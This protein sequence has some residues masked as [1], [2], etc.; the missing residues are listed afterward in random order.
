MS[1]SLA[2]R[3]STECSE[4]GGA[5]S[6]AANFC[7]QCGAKIR[8]SST[9]GAE[10]RQVTVVF[11]DLVGSTALSERL[12]P[13]ELRDLICLYQEACGKVVERFGG[14]VAQ[15]LGDGILIY[16][17]YPKA[18]EDDAQRSVHASLGIIEA[19]GPLNRQ[20]KS[21]REISLEVRL[22]IHTG[23]VV[24]GNIGAA[25]HRQEKLALGSTP[26]VA[27]RLQG[28]AEPNAV[29]VSAEIHRLTEDFFVWQ[30]LG[31]RELKGTQPMEVYRA[32]A[33]S[34]LRSRFEV[35]LSRGL[36]PF[37]GRVEQ[38]ETLRECHRLASAGEGRAVLLRG[39]GGIGKSRI[40]HAFIECLEPAC[41]S[42]TGYCSAYAQNTALAP[43]IPCLKRLLGFAEDD[44]DDNR[45][46]KLEQGLE[47]VHEPAPESLIL[48]ASLLEISLDGRFP[49]LQLDPELQRRRTL[50][51]VAAVFVGEAALA[52]LV[53]VIEDLHWIDPSTAVFLDILFARVQHSRLL[54]ILSSRPSFTPHWANPEVVVRLD[55]DRLGTE[56][57]R[58]LVENMGDDRTLPEDMV[59]E[60]V[61][62]ADGIPLFAEELTK[63]LLESVTSQAGEDRGE[64]TCDLSDLSIPD[65]LHGSLM[66]RLDGLKIAK[67]TAQL[68][69][70]VGR[71]FSYELLGQ[72]SELEESVLRS[73]LDELLHTEILVQT[74]T[75]PRL[76]YN[77]RHALLQETAYDSLLKSVRRQYH[78]RIAETVVAGFPV[79]AAREPEYVAL[80]FTAAGEHD[81]AS[82]FWRRAAAQAVER[83]AFK[84][85]T[86]HVSRGLEALAALPDPSH[87]WDW[88]LELQLARG[89]AVTAVQGH[90]L[91]EAEQA[92]SRALELCENSGEN[93]AEIF[94]VLWGLGAI[95][96]VRGEPL[97]ALK[98][99]RRH[100]DLARLSGKPG[101][102]VD[103]C[104]GMGSTR[105]LLGDFSEAG[106]HFAE[107]AKIY[108]SVP[109]PSENPSS[110]SIYNA[111]VMSAMYNFVLSWYVGYPDRAQEEVRS[112]TALAE[113]LPHPSRTANILAWSAWLHQLAGRQREVLESAQAASKLAAEFGFSLQGDLAALWVAWASIS[114]EAPEE[115]LGRFYKVIDDYRASGSR[116]LL[117]YFLYLYAEALLAA[118][119][120]TEA[121]AVVEETLEHVERSNERFSEAD[122]RRLEGEIHWALEP[123]QPERAAK[124]FSHA[125]DIAR[126]QGARSLELRATVSAA[127][128][129]A[130]RG[131]RQR[132]ARTA[133][134]SS[135]GI[136][137]RRFDPGSYS[138]NEPVERARQ[139]LGRG[140]TIHGFQNG[141]KSL[142]VGEDHLT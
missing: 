26:N 139:P 34:G 67:E 94:W 125:L 40:L 110:H 59:R 141:G 107:A 77:F 29:V 5:V 41:R 73:H 131:E 1:D 135:H 2:D 54:V 56:Q 30:S 109:N 18:H 112:T 122:L 83:Y 13:E 95:N 69:A 3:T 113:K 60:I 128:L 10:R 20:I 23:S 47:R 68:A 86:E 103:A 37:V 99:A 140:L 81:P 35:T 9:S 42:Q 43:I 142:A 117:T 98:I 15:Y 36:R 17:G 39:E 127:R 120:P 63:T 62:R 89:A 58:A 132:A 44:S 48:L 21:G 91:P 123:G 38:L 31:R 90:T 51:T 92:Y 106:R 124:C 76:A 53:L 101:P 7:Q 4:C 129:M 121:L 28:L 66:A 64:L 72:V 79:V 71:E 82:D 6:A 14:Y 108:G 55:L 105:F 32:L 115:G 45:L 130:D 133:R 52:P 61:S 137:G 8:R 96:Q 22:G 136:R 25:G 126:S 138:G 134:E 87:R 80:H 88:E 33:V 104:F 70:V 114:D 84:E 97:R 93:R 50:E 46:E 118:D 111:G 102:V 119:R 78:R 74:K 11:C 24:T 65:T 16:F 49:P 100:R 12:D 27:A 75:I 57:T 19:M 85:A 116:F